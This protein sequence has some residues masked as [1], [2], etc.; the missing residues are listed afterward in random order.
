MSGSG[1]RR[2]FAWLSLA[3]ALLAVAVPATAAEGPRRPNVL[4]IAVDDLND[5]TGFL[6][7]HPQARTPNLDRLA[8]RGVHFT[9][10]YCPAPACNPSRTSLMT[11][12]LPSTTGVYHN[13][14]PW[15]PVLPDAVTLPQH[16][17][18]AGYD[19]AGGGKI[20]HNSFNDR[21]SWPEWFGLSGRDHPKP[22]QVPAND[23]PRTAHFDWGP[24]DVPD[25]AMGD[26]KTV[27]WAIDWLDADRDRP[28]FLA[29]GLIRPH[30]PW[31]APR[32][33][34]DHYPIGE[35]ALPEA[36]A[37]DLDD[38]PPAGIAMAKPEGDHRKVVEA[39]QWEE[40]VQGYL[41]SI[42]FADAQIGRL[43]DALDAS[44]HRDDTIIVFWG[45]HGWHLGEKEHWRKFALWEEAT[46][47]PLIVV[48]PGV[49]GPNGRSERTV[50]LLDLY[51]TL[52]DLCD[53]PLRPG[54]EGEGLTPLLRDPAAS[55]DRPV[56][57]THGRGNHAVRS[58]RWR[59]IRYADGS[60]EL[61]DHEA[62]PREWTNLADDPRWQAVTAEL[63][64]SLPKTDAP[65]APRAN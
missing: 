17:T 27:S 1:S 56:V 54:L 60:E 49:T 31:Y 47:V 29:V 43:L 51:P 16:F 2:I 55:W 21:A 26:H 61:Y 13:N 8:A 15:R 41:A 32:P 12:F 33:Y 39:G 20:F 35:I 46:R 58:E 34:F 7:G 52:I 57:T 44:G 50:S 59:Y 42:E 18:A 36:L 64:E 6:G 40:A 19:V 3:A 45:D 53:L 5:W 25:E 14:Q 4:F 37:D 63:A 11:G 24:V 62:D 48:A 22:D 38:V 9:R 65:D 30:L 23:I 28:F 10:A